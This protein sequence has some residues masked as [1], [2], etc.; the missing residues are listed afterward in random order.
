MR[1]EIF[2]AIESGDAERVTKLADAAGERD[3]DGV[4]ALLFA[5][6][7]GRNDLVAAL[8]PRRGELDVFEAA[9]LGD[10]DRLRELRDAQRPAE[11]EHRQCGQ[12]RGAHA[13]GDVLACHKAQE[14]DGRRVQRIGHQIEVTSCVHHASMVVI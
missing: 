1:H 12:P 11:D 10:V 8:R 3:A 2:E 5:Q 13:R 7:Y 9:A 6:Y 14:V 4:S